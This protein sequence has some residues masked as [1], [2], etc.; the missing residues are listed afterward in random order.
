MSTVKQFDSDPRVARVLEIKHELDLR[1]AL[2][3]EFDKLILELAAEGFKSVEINGNSILLIDNVAKIKEGKNTVWKSAGIKL[4]DIE[5]IP[6]D[7][8]IARTKRAEKKVKGA[9]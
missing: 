2:Y 1:N 6:T 4:F 8:L 9:V 7:K 5:E 3:D